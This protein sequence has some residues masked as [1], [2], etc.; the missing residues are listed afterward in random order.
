M[1]NRLQFKNFSYEAASKQEDRR[2]VYERFWVIARHTVDENYYVGRIPLNA[3][4]PDYFCWCKSCKQLNL[5]ILVDGY[6]SESLET[7]RI[8]LLIIK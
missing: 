7:T 2:L 1:S 5:G 4:Q 8:P 6:L 3:H